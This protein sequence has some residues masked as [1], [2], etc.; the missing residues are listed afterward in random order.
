MDELDLLEYLTLFTFMREQRTPHEM[1]IA[2]LKI[3]IR[4]LGCD[5]LRGVFHADPSRGK[6]FLLLF[7]RDEPED[8]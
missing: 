8:E 3:S 1:D 7:E 2:L 5:H 4:T 6:N